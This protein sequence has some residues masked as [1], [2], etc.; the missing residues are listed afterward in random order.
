[1]NS[2]E[3]AE[4]AK[5]KDCSLLHITR[6]EIDLDPDIDIHSEEVYR[7]SVDNFNLWQKRGWLVQDEDPSYYIY[8]QTMK[9]GP[10]TVLWDALRLQIIL[11][12]SLR[13]M[14][15][16]DPIRNKTE[17]FIYI[18]TMP[19]SNRSF[20][21][22]LVEELDTIVEK[23][24]RTE[25][26]EYDFVAKDGFG[27]HFWVVRDADTVR[28]SKNCSPQRCPLHMSP[29]DIT[30]V[31]QHVSKEKGDNNPFIQGR[32]NITILAVHF[33]SNHQDY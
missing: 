27:H 32:K 21:L 23:I 18:L 22:S 6:A 8:A 10:S 26:P 12:V 5:G 2:K 11:T 19:I 25:K 28:G 16:Q 7:K 24:V 3:A 4:M 33:P 14:S 1:M 17:W 30:E 31:Q 15:L 9:E 29:T 13:G 20:C